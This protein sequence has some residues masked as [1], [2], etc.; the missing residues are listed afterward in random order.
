MLRY[1]LNDTEIC[2]MNKSKYF[3]YNMRATVHNGVYVAS[4]SI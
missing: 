1:K 4:I 3:M 2:G